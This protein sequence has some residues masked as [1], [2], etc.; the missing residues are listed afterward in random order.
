[1]KYRNKSL[2]QQADELTIY[3]QSKGIRNGCEREAKVEENG[4]VIRSRGNF[5]VVLLFQVPEAEV[6]RHGVSG[7]HLPG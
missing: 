7:E 6:L 4:E 3:R 2:I 5:A 1:M